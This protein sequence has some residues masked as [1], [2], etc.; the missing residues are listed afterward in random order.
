MRLFVALRLEGEGEEALDRA[1]VVARSLLAGARWV[2][3]ENRHLT[4]K[5]LGEVPEERVGEVVKALSGLRH[6]PFSSPLTSWGAFP[7]E[8]AARVLWVG[9]GGQDVHGLAR[10]VEEAMGDL[11]FARENRPFEAHI[12]VARFRS[13]SRLDLSV[14][15]PLPS[16]ALQARTFVLYRSR[17]QPTGAEYT[18]LATFSLRE[19]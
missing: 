17:L 11:G 18:P 4:L 5:F 19:D 8:R 1:V 3:R 13:P 9:L 16:S 15:P 6:P 2:P 10:R 14:L 12:T 7:S